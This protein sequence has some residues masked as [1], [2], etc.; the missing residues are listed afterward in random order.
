[1]L[2]RAAG[3]G[4]ASTSN[5]TSL[6]STDT[7][8]HM[9]LAFF[10]PLH[11]VRGKRGE[12]M[13]QRAVADV[14]ANPLLLPNVTLHIETVAADANAA[15]SIASLVELV[16]RL[17][18]SANALVTFIYLFVRVASVRSASARMTC[19]CVLYN[20]AHANLTFAPIC[21]T[22]APLRHRRAVLLLSSLK[23]GFG[24]SGCRRADVDEFSVGRQSHWRSCLTSGRPRLP[25]RVA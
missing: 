3:V 15:S 6:N 18:G 4:G 11:T 19:I 13:V 10:V 8:E 24:C 21:I 7:N 14:N 23:A 17:V 9:H 16:A 25:G 12:W 1:V 22:A 20:S 2:V 5:S